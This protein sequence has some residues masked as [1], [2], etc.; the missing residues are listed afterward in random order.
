MK[1]YIAT[2][3]IMCIFAPISAFSIAAK[4]VGAEQYDA[5]IRFNSEK[6]SNGIKKFGIGSKTAMLRNPTVTERGG[7][8]CWDIAPTVDEGYVYIDFDT[9]VGS[10]AD[11]GSTYDVEIDYFDYGAGFMFC[12]YDD[13]NYG[14]QLAN[15]IYTKNT[16]AWKT[17]RFTLENAAFGE[18]I[19]G[20]DLMLATRTR[21]GWSDSASTAHMYIKEIRVKRNKAAQPI[22]AESYIEEWGNV[23]AHTDEKKT[24][25]VTYKNTLAA[26]TEFE[27]S[28]RLVD[29]TGIERWALS[30]KYE[31]EKNGEVKTE[32]NFDTDFCG[33]YT[34]Y[35]DIAGSG[36]AYTIKEDTIA[37]V[38]RDEYGRASESMY[39]SSE[40][41]PGNGYTVEE[42]RGMISM[43][44]KANFSGNRVANMADA[45]LYKEAG[46]Q[47][48]NQCFGGFSARDKSSWTFP[49]TEEEFEKF[50]NQYRAQAKKMKD[51]GFHLYELWNE[52]NLTVF[53]PLNQ[54]P[55]E[56]VKMQKAFYETVKSVDPEAE[57]S[58]LSITGIDTSSVFD[59]WYKG[60][61][62]AGLFNY[63]TAISLHPYTMQNKPEQVYINNDIQKYK[64]YAAE[65]GIE[66]IPIWNTEYGHTTADN[67]PDKERASWI[68][69]DTLLFKLNNVGQINVPY[70]LEQKGPRDNDREDCFGFTS[71]G[72]YDYNIEGKTCVPMASYAALAAM[73]YMLI[74]TDAQNSGE[75]LET[76]GN[77][78]TG[79]LQSK[80]FGKQVMPMWTANKNET[81]TLS[82]GT[83]N[84]DFYDGYGNKQTLLSDDGIYSFY[85]TGRPCYLVGDFKDYKR[86]EENKFDFEPESPKASNGGTAEIVVKDCRNTGAEIDADVP[87]GCYVEERTQEG[88]SNKFNIAFK[89]EL[90]EEKHVEVRIKHDGKLTG[91]AYIP[92][93]IIVPTTI[94]IRFSPDSGDDYDKWKGKITVTNNLANKVEKGYIQFSEPN[95]FTNLGKVSLGYVPRSSTVETEFDC[96]DIRQKGMYSLKYKAVF[97]DG[98]VYDFNQLVDF[99]MATYAKTK[100]NID[101][102]ESE[103][104]WPLNTAMRA[105]SDEY[106]KQIK[107]WGGADDL[108]ADVRLMWDEENLYMISN[109][110]DNVQRNVAE[111]LNKA[112]QGDGIQLALYFIDQNEFIAIGQGGTNFNE[113]IIARLDD[114]TVGTYMNKVQRSGQK[115]RLLDKAQTAIERK[116]NIT[117][118][119]W[120]IAWKDMLEGSGLDF[121]P[122]SGT[123]I[124][125]SILWNDDDG[126]GRRGWIEYASGIGEY[127]DSSL[128]TY[129]NLVK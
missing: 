94:N 121:D 69:R 8:E 38:K 129:L 48:V 83:E 25:N 28:Y 3:L 1:R 120:S 113:F 104:E 45:D 91:F 103:G 80:K 26:D 19:L 20:Y 60:T 61:A 32:I 109:V 11:D 106:V 52:P 96:P 77:F 122:K 78:H 54:S 55:E 79:R 116:G 70:N 95:M 49:E 126:E 112:W 98:N 14:K 24:A 118:Y 110:K 39:T 16:K 33:L 31:I 67:I 90:D 93:T 29:D 35:I 124:G 46:L 99:T 74:G 100:P 36:F 63:A 86:L 12:W 105:D 5:V 102:I 4:D 13:M 56:L 92:V 107:N 62:A 119:E 127:K 47:I 6:Y 84:V 65:N 117:T 81:V 22:L 10:S 75:M 53:N 51:L 64:D 68:V 15:E 85:V 66:N 40:I 89:G 42:R 111:G 37:I 9:P 34:L 108:S 71:P 114:G 123:R 72:Y 7:E 50:K 82:L 101:G 21:R 30:R 87:W 73:N 76:G 23:F 58:G 125:F 97:N 2:L 59:K 18:G 17:S 27:A 128:F 44:K 57:I 41:A 43:V 115:A 88:N